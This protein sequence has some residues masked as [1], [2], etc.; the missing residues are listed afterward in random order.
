MTENADSISTLQK[1]IMHGGQEMF[2]LAPMALQNILE[3]RM[4]E[5]R[6]D[7]KGVDFRDFEHFAT[8]LRWQG[9]E[10][11]IED[12][13]LLCRKDRYQHVRQMLDAEIG[14]LAEHGANQHVGGGDNVTSSE[15]RGNN[16]VYT[17]RRLK[18]DRPDLAL[19]VIAGEMSANAAAIEAGFRKKPTVIE[20]LERLWHRASDVEKAAFL[21]WLEDEGT[22]P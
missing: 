7:H 18:R 2:D 15:A 4:W 20:Q 9:L 13:R 8:S 6:R 21:S 12:L 19:R 16:P 22:E 10:T 14:A 5:G 1:I 11:S 17:L 3:G